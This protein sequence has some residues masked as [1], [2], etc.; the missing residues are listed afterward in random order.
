MIRQIEYCFAVASNW[1]TKSFE[2]RLIVIGSQCWNE[3]AREKSWNQMLVAELLVWAIW[4]KDT[5]VSHP[6]LLVL[7]V[8]MMART[9]Q[10][11][12]I[13]WSCQHVYGSWADIA[14]NICNIGVCSSLNQVP[15]RR[16]RIFF[17]YRRNMFFRQR[18]SSAESFL[19]GEMNSWADLTEHQ[20]LAYISCSQL[21]A[22][23][24]RM[25]LWNHFGVLW[26]RS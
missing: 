17:N 12:S 3:G 24:S 6:G 20:V 1:A 26:S 9:V 16:K 4:V 21:M 23:S 14:P 8:Q 18:H 15:S 13:L 10:T 7:N 2:R 25:F 19:F 5:K 22:G 11:F